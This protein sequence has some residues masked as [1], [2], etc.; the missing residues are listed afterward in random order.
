MPKKT[1]QLWSIPFYGS[2]QIEVDKDEG[3][4]HEDIN[5]LF[6]NQYVGHVQLYDVVDS[7][8]SGIEMIEEYDESN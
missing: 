2:Y 3:Y 5:R 1:K 6:W 8:I 4:D 7:D